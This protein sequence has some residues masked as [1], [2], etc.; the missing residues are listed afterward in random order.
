MEHA[1]RRA[2]D[3]PFR[4]QKQRAAI[5]RAILRA[6][7]ILIL[8]DSLSAVDSETEAKIQ[9]RLRDVV[10]KRTTLLIAHRLSSLRD[11]DEIVVLE[12]GRIAER[13]SHRELVARG[14]LYAR[15][16]E[17]QRLEEEVESA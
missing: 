4:G 14:G 6:P 16:W 13:G 12:E 17:R 7:K 1:D 8:D 10:S 9:N 2:G 3:H 5:A 11:A 15:M